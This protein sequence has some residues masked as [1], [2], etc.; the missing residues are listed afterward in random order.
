MMTPESTVRDEL[1]M[2]MDMSISDFY[3]NKKTHEIQKMKKIR[4]EKAIER[5]LED[6]YEAHQFQL[7]NNG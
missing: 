4:I 7:L 2:W 6:R 5:Q 1:P 3:P